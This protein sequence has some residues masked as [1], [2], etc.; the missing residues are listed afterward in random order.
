MPQSVDAPAPL[1]TAVQSSR[2]VF[3]LLTAFGA[4]L[5]GWFKDAVEQISLFEPAKQIGTGL[6]INLTTIVAAITIAGLALA[7]FA[8]MDD[9]HKGRTV[10]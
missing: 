5:I 7:L 8:R 4:T 6:G 10:K 2:T 1:T 3:G 9:A